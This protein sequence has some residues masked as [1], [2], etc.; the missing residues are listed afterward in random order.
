MDVALGCLD[1]GGTKVLAALVSGDGAVLATQRQPIASYDPLTVAEQ[2]AQMLTGLAQSQERRIAAIGCS[3]PGPLDRASG[4]IT[5]SPNLGWRDVPF[6]QMLQER[7]GVAAVIDDDAR[8]AA[9]GEW[10][11][12]C[13]RGIAHFMYIIVGTGIGGGIVVNGAPLYG[14][15]DTA[16]EIGH[17]TVRRGGPVCRCGKAG[18]LEAVASGRAIAR[19]GAEAVQS[20]AST[21]LAARCEGEAGRMTAEMVVAAARDGDPISSQIVTDA[22]QWLG[23]GLANATNLLNPDLIVL[24]GGLMLGASDLLLPPTLGSLDAHALPSARGHVRIELG[25]LGEQAGLIGAAWTAWQSLAK[26]PR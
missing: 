24:G 25:M 4:I 26:R 21:A 7:L 5:S 13:A 23:I 1:I 18:C 12:G 11:R 16:G 6:R 20:G 14:A 9:I 8:C 19:E 15:G 2:C 3:V 17:T 22:G 10:W